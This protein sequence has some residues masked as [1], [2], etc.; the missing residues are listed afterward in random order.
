[1]NE[2]LKILKG[3]YRMREKGLTSLSSV[4]GG[5]NLTK[6]QIDRAIKDVES[7]VIGG[8][9]DSLPGLDLMEDVSKNISAT[10]KIASKEARSI[11]K[12][13]VQKA[14][15]K[16]T[17]GEYATIETAPTP[18]GKKGKGSRSKGRNK[19]RSAAQ[20]T[21]KSGAVNL[22]RTI[23]SRLK[24]AEFN[25][26]L[27][28][29]A[30]RGDKYAMRMRDLMSAA[31]EQSK[32]GPL[33]FRPI[34]NRNGR[35]IIIARNNGANMFFNMDNTA[36]LFE[37]A[38]FASYAGLDL[39]QMIGWAKN[40]GRSLS[41]QMQEAPGSKV[42]IGDL[43]F[44]PEEKADLR[45]LVRETQK[46]EAKGVAVGGGEV[47][48]TLGESVSGTVGDWKVSP[49][50]SRGNKMSLFDKEGCLDAVRRESPQMAEQMMGGASPINVMMSK[51][52]M[53]N[54]GKMVERSREAAGE[55]YEDDGLGELDF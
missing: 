13:R 10:T 3:L 37:L 30:G 34:Y 27:N 12:A 52:K 31:E 19:F 22:D 39:S 28:M 15:E 29:A 18:R 6:E 48:A 36:D 5:R 23:P 40:N 14:K 49:E 24:N 54:P 38:K 26:R 21:V 32:V 33:F 47:T 25:D 35:Q 50:V 8:E 9:G 11:A 41:S 55:V 45:D 53:P 1:M 7:R 17:L 2:K 20:K 43:S 42:V 46:E 16:K 51:P 4:M 44:Q